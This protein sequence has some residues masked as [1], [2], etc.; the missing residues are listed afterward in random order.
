[1][2]GRTSKAYEQI[3]DSFVRI[4]YLFEQVNILFG[5]ICNSSKL[6]PPLSP[7]TACPLSLLK[8][9]RERE[10]E[11]EREKHFNVPFIFLFSG[12]QTIN[13][14]VEMKIF[15]YLSEPNKP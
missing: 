15:F 11:R 10:R 14:F 5:R 4:S 8:S 12:V 6:D 3:K 7:C 1:M 9:E 13:F 2:F